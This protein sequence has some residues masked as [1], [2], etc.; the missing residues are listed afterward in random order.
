MEILIERKCAIWLRTRGSGEG[1]RR[2]GNQGEGALTLEKVSITSKVREC[3]NY[4]SDYQRTTDSCCSNR[5]RPQLNPIVLCYF[6]M[7]ATFELVARWKGTAGLGT[8][9]I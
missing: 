5:W 1:C 3:E 8:C 7:T 2:S 4:K 6:S 9:E